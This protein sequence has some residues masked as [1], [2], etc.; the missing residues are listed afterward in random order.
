MNNSNYQARSKQFQQTTN[1]LQKRYERLGWIRLLCFIFLIA[2]IIVAFREFPW[3][4]SIP[5]TML[6]IAAFARLVKWHGRIQASAQHHQHLATINEQEAKSLLGERDTLYDGAV[7]VDANH[8]YAYDLDIFGPFSLYQLVNRAQTSIGRSLL[9]S[10]LKKP[11]DKDTI[12]ERQTAAAELSERVDWQHH[13]RAYGAAIV[14]EGGQIERLYRWLERPAVVQGRPMRIVALWIAPLLFVTALILWIWYVPWFVAILLFIPAGLWL[15]NSL[16]EIQQLHNE[17]GR[18]ADTLR[19]YAALMAHIEVAQ[20]TS[21]P[22]QQLQASFLANEKVASTAI[23]QLA[24]RL[25]QLDVRYNAF[26][27]LLEFSMVWD[28]Q[29]AY[30][31]DRWKATYKDVL[32]SWFAALAQVE[33]LVSLG[34]ISTNYPGWTTPTIV[35]TPQLQVNAL[36]HPLLL[37]DKRVD[38]DLSMTTQGHMHLITGSNMAGKSTWLRTV[39]CNIVLALAGANVCAKRFQTPPLQVYTSM[40]TQ[41]ALHEST[42]S[43]YA[44][45]KRLKFIIEAVEDPTKTDGRPVFFLL[46][47]ILKGT[48]SRDRHTGAKALIRQLIAS[49]GAGLIAT[50]DLEL[51]A[52]EAEANGRIENWAIEVDI[53]DGQLFFDYT[54]KR[55]VSKSFNATLLMQRMG[56]KIEG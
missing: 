6:G 48:N 16:E 14:E 15:R 32:P 49:K 9:A 51:G 24:Y 27:F 21:L 45:L 34:N 17:T 26:V 12:I 56:I 38:N 4:A 3:W 29:Q 36:G 28:L 37:A 46:D 54:L 22:L 8:P 50:H 52:L 19:N 42:S 25:S 10:W 13:F 47:E 41:D 18:A 53:R 1:D 2:L 23:K 39:G 55:G 31:L 43:F 44:E 40:R 7:F 5:T 35:D 11:T 33:A 20:F 30:R